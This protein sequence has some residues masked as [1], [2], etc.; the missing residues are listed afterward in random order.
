MVAKIPPSS[1]ASANLTYLSHLAKTTTAIKSKLTPPQLSMFRKTVFGHL[2]DLDLVFNVS[3]IH[4]ILLREIEDS[5]TPNTISFNL[6]GSKVLFRRREF[7][8]I[9]G[10]KYDR[11]PVRKDTSPHRLRALYFND[12]ND[13]LLSD[14]EKI[15][16]VTRFEDDFDAAKISIVYLMELVLL[17]RERT[18]KYDY[19]LLGIVDDCE[20]CCNH[21]WGMMSF[22]KTIYSLKRGPTKRS[23]DGGFRKLYSL[24]GFP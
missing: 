12:S 14:F 9:S 5:S 18:L 11:S 10:L 20:T 1:N 23:K 22:D 3:L 21:D 15:Y 13:I 16:I 24:Y 19:T 2:L 17:G 4:K 8:I 6:F 7:D